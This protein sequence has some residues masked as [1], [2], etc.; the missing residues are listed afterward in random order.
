ML[1][2][3][4]HAWQ[5]QVD[6]YYLYLCIFKQIANCSPL[7]RGEQNQLIASVTVVIIVKKEEK[8]IKL[9]ETVSSKLTTRVD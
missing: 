8:Q 6:G 3:F 1:G 4:P 7:F 5:G 2:H 9:Q